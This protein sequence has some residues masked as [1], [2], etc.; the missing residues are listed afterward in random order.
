MC[1]ASVLGPVPGTVC[2]QLMR[3]GKRANVC[4]RGQSM[5]TCCGWELEIASSI[6]HVSDFKKQEEGR[7]AS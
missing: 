3:Q 7:T 5:V 6:S 2:A 4:S 1:W